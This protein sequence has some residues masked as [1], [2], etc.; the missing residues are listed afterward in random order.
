[1]TAKRL[2]RI[3]RHKGDRCENCRLPMVDEYFK[4]VSYR[5]RFCSVSCVKAYYA[6]EDGDAETT[7]DNPKS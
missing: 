3:E 1:M 6:D 7:F 2:I 4:S 5:T